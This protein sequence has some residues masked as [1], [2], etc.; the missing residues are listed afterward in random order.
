MC[1]RL[2]SGPSFQLSTQ[3]HSALLS[4]K[5]YTLEFGNSERCR[6]QYKVM[7]ST[8]TV[9]MSTIMMILMRITAMIIMTIIII[10]IIDIILII[11]I[12]IIIIDVSVPGLL[13][14]RL[15]YLPPPV[16]ALTPSYWCVLPETF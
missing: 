8:C 4:T 12:I 16:P 3:V 7:F 10:I 6:V 1:T 11:I 13:Q 2:E 5:V 15:G 9:M 14:R